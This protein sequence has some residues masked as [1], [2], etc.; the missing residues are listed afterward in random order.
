MQKDIMTIKNVQSQIERHNGTL[1]MQGKLR[2]A[3]FD[4]ITEQDVAEIVR[5]QVLKAKNGDEQSLQF[6]MRYV[7]GFGQ[8][9]AIQQINVG[10]GS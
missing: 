9:P 2:Q 4:S 1:E 6:V 5:K 7:L 10:R 8:P 3:I